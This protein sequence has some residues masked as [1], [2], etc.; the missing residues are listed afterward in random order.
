MSF[1]KSNKP[2]RRHRPKKVLEEIDQDE[3]CEKREAKMNAPII[4]TVISVIGSFVMLGIVVMGAPYSY[5]SQQVRYE[6]RDVKQ[7]KSL[8]SLGKKERE[9]ADPK[10]L[11]DF[12]KIITPMDK[13]RS[14]AM[15]K[16]AQTCRQGSRTALEAVT[17]NK[18]YKSFKKATRF[19]TC[20]M[21]TE[22]DRFCHAE[23]RQLLVDQLLEYKERRQNVFAFEKYREKALAKREKFNQ[24]QIEAGQTPFPPLVFENTATLEREIDPGLLSQ[25]E[26]LVANGYISPTDFGYHGFYLPTEFR[27]ALAVGAD[28]YAPC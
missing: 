21:A 16:V 17:P 19:L 2:Q 11:I 22:R 25:L 24:A 20:A 26:N 14:P 12:T 13:A 3:V 9:E 7:A 10:L 6:S 4:G 8:V 23:E 1:G 27:D 18:A 15:K 5:G 28:R